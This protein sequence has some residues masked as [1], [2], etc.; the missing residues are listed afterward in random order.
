MLPIFWHRQLILRSHT[1]IYLSC[2]PVM[3]SSLFL[4]ATSSTFSWPSRTVTGFMTFDDRTD[5]SYLLIGAPSISKSSNLS[6]EAEINFG[7]EGVNRS[8]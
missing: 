2:P 3:Q 1:P 7:S 8:A 6:A 4:K 5:P